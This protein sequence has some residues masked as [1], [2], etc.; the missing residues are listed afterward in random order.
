MAPHSAGLTKEFVL[1]NIIVVNFNLIVP[2]SDIEFKC[3][4]W[5]LSDVVVVINCN[6]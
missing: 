5:I 6:F 4:F 1:C 3:N 2:N